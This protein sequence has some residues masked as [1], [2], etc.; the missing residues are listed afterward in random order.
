VRKWRAILD[1]T[2]QIANWREGHLSSPSRIAALAAFAAAVTLL[3]AACDSPAKFRARRAARPDD[4]R[5]VVV[6]FAG[7]TGIGLAESSKPWVSENGPRAAFAAIRPAW[8]GA[9]F[10][11]ANLEAPIT[12]P[13]RPSLEGVR[14]PRQPLGV[15]AAFAAEGI[16]A[17][18]LANNH[19]MDFGVEGLRDTKRS[20]DAASIGAVGAG[21]SASEADQPLVLEKNG[22]KIG[23]LAGCAAVTKRLDGVARRGKPGAAHMTSAWLRRRISRLR[24]KVDYVVVFAH[25]GECYRTEWNDRQHDL[26]VAAVRAGADLVVG[27]HP[28]LA[29]GAELI[30][31]VPVFYSLGNFV[32]HGVPADPMRTARDDFGLIALAEF[33][34]RA[35][36]RITLVPFAVN[37]V[38]T[39]FTPRLIGE[40][41]IKRLF[42]RV[43]LPWR[44]GREIRDGR[45]V[46]L[47]GE[48]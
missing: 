30:D 42:D 35:V 1:C 39:D 28:H 12:T 47:P 17:F 6:A 41:P 3:T 2:R 16:S 23:V 7:D 29:Q 11:I 38:T 19:V 24:P 8:Q 5:T 13:D 4:G 10:F 43:L 48:G 44:A 37:N 15:E 31:G 32:Y 27:C 34:P 21:E 25:W 22:L 45:A 33:G 46:L 9:D 26:A 20:L 40:A 14:R 18:S 36:R